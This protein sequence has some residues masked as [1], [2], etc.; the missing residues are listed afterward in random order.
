MGEKWIRKLGSAPKEGGR[1]EETLRQGKLEGTYW[2]EKLK[3]PRGLLEKTR[4]LLTIV[5]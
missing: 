5:T 2:T 3:G 4:L 1:G